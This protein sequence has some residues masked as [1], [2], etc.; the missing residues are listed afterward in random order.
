MRGGSN[1]KHD[2]QTAMN[3]P[4]EHLTDNAQKTTFSTASEGMF[5][6]GFRFRDVAV[7][8]H[9]ERKQRPHHTWNPRFSDSLPLVVS[10]KMRR[11]S[12]ARVPLVCVDYVRLRW[13]PKLVKHGWSC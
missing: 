2:G 8:T 1:T 11:L 13:A 7:A 10:L 5:G 4:V 12:C 9:T 6:Q 3:T